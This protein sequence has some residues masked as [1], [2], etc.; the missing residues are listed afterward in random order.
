MHYGKFIRYNIIGGSVWVLA[1]TLTGYFFG[2][3]PFVKNNFEYVILGIVALSLIPVI[4]QFFR[5]KN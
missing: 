1:L 4:L 5:K 2:N 3:L